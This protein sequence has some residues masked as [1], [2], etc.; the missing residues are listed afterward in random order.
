MP[1]DV[2]D[3]PP[4]PAGAT[5]PRSAALRLVAS[6]FW[7]FVAALYCAQTLA[8]M[9]E[10]PGE[11]PSLVTAIV[12]SGG[13]YLAWIPLTVLLWRVT[14][15]WDPAA[16]GWGR[17]ALRH[18]AALVLATVVHSAIV[19]AGALSILGTG[20]SKESLSTMLVGQMRGRS[21]QEVIIY[22]AV[23]ASGQ[24][25]L[26][27]DRWRERQTHA[28]RLEAQL[29]AARL[30]AL[31]AQLQPHFLFN[32][33]HAVAS[34]V[35]DGRGDDAV[36]LISGMSDLLRRVLDRGASDHPIEDELALVRAYLDIQRV[37]FGDRLHVSV[38]AAP[39]AANARVPV[40]IVQPLVENALRHGLADKVGPGRVDIVIERDGPTL[41]IRVSDDGMGVPEDWRAG[42]APGTGSANL[43]A[44][45]DALY[46]PGAS[47]S[48]TGS[49]APGSWRRFG[50]RWSRVTA[51]PLRALVVDDEPL[52]RGGCGFGSPRGRCHGRRGSADRP[53]AVA[54]IRSSGPTSSSSTSRFQEMMDS[55]FWR[56][57]RGAAARGVRHRVR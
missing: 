41:E 36:R 3:S 37:R 44:R 23:V 51:G 25:F 5:G 16:L 2:T 47:L 31:R 12:W 13:F 33:L 18:L 20:S 26:L 32:S 38:V 8:L 17:T 24:A 35:R 45:L 53:S 55:R 42:R 46:G 4:S 19:I 56:S 27:Y 11:L 50:C 34:L 9:R 7:S 29:A 43:T 54:G 6:L 1:V 10:M 57:W 14:P 52:A 48:A 22:A 21:Y 49:P 30:D 39:E 40:L 28:A 15:R